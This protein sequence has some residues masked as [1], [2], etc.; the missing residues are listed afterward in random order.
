MEIGDSA[1]SKKAADRN[2]PPRWRGPAKRLDIDETGV[3]ADFRSQSLKVARHRASGK[4]DAQGV[5][6]VQ[7]GPAS[8]TAA[9]WVGVA[10]EDLGSVRKNDGLPLGGEGDPVVSGTASPKESSD[11]NA[12]SCSSSPAPRA[13]PVPGSPPL[14]VQLSFSPPRST[15]L[16]LHVSP[17]DGNCV[18]SQVPPVDRGRY[19]NLS[20]DQ[21]HELCR[22]RG[23]GRGDSKEVSNTRLASMDAEE[24]KR[25]STRDG[26][27]ETLVAVTGKGGR[28]PVAVAGNV[29]FPLGGRETRCRVDGLHSAFVAGKDVAQQHAQRRNPELN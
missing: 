27:V 23:Y 21:V 13:V 6:E 2:S 24:R 18:P 8:G 5:G 22:R 15:Q 11:V 17:F 4:M 12:I 9:P 26:F 3:T 1:P 7:W 28:A 25:T 20:Y 16:S 19:A 29:D 10:L 14:S